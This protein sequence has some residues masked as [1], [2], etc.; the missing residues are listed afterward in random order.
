MRVL[1]GILFPLVGPP[2]EVAQ[3]PRLALP[4]GYAPSEVV[5]LGEGGGGLVKISA[6]C[7]RATIC[8]YSNAVSG[9]VGVGLRRTWVS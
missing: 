8:L 6:S 9:L 5:S 7:L 3:G 2:S 1:V 4:L